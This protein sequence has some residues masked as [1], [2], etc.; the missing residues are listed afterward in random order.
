MLH[1]MLDYPTETITF[2]VH[3]PRIYLQWFAIGFSDRG[4]IFP[5]DYCILTSGWNRVDFVVSSDI[6]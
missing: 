2:E 5:A 1:W 3:L 4:D 6:C